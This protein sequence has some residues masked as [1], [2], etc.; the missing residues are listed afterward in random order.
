MASDDFEIG[1]RP[2]ASAEF[3]R[4]PP[5]DQAEITRIVTLLGMDPWVDSVAKFQF[6]SR[7][8]ILNVYDDGEWVVV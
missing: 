5:I 2:P 3:R 4:L 1:W 8:V 6:V 7:V